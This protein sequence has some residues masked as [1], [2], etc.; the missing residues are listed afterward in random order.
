VSRPSLAAGLRTRA[1]SSSPVR[2]S[3]SLNRVR[4]ILDALKTPA[5]LTRRGAWTSGRLQDRGGGRLH[6]RC[7][8]A[9]LRNAVLAARRNRITV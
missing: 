7:D 5:C 1:Q 4:A 2:R 3:P 8:P 6:P 9:H